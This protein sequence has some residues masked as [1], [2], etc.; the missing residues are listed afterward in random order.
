MAI[1]GI[2]GS[3]VPNAQLFS[4]AGSTVASQG[5]EFAKASRDR[6]PRYWDPLGKQTPHTN[7]L[8]LKCA[9]NKMAA[10]ALRN[11][12]KI[13]P[14]PGSMLLRGGLPEAGGFLLD[15]MDK[16][17]FDGPFSLRHNRDGSFIFA[18][19]DGRRGCNGCSVKGL[20][21]LT[22]KPNGQASYS[23]VR[24]PYLS[25]DVDPAARHANATYNMLETLNAATQSALDQS[26]SAPVQL[27]KPSDIKPFDPARVAQAVI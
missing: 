9:T 21:I 14:K 24:K 22:I 17:G 26:P 12:Q 1:A 15:G 11:C 13:L 18:Q 10:A 2:G 8:A 27:P 3:Q 6:V 23:P 5:K 19:D 16:F 25:P 4:Q 20:D 7:P